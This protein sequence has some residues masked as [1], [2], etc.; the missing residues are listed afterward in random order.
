[1]I[2]FVCKKEKEKTFSL[3]IGIVCPNCTD[4]LFRKY[5]LV[6]KRCHTV[7]FLPRDVESKQFLI[8]KGFTWDD[9]AK[10]VYFPFRSCEHCETSK[11][12]GNA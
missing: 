9:E 2:C 3:K 7:D 10:I 5:T 4:K 8:S 6:C 1:M 12:I 11:N